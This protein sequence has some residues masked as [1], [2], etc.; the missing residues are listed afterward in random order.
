MISSLDGVWNTLTPNFLSGYA[1]IY[2]VMLRLNIFDV[3]W[4]VWNA[5]GFPFIPD[6]FTSS[7][8]WPPKVISSKSTWCYMSF[9]S[10]F[11]HRWDIY[12]RESKGRKEKCVLPTLPSQTFVFE[13]LVVK[14]QA[15]RGRTFVVQ[16]L[17][18][19]LREKNNK[20]ISWL[21]LNAIRIGQGRLFKL[22]KGPTWEK[23]PM[24]CPWGCMW[25]IGLNIYSK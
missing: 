8:I 19:P 4:F 24:F 11:S 1:L 7:G 6:Y 20:V 10:L 21:L 18:L 13:D 3:V 9:L 14:K 2:T 23:N 17:M 16:Y 15:M 22:S 5:M 25:E 12:E